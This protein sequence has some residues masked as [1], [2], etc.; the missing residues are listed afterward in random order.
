MSAKLAAAQEDGFLANLPLPQ[1][2]LAC[3]AITHGL[4]H[5]I[6]DDVD[7]LGALDADAA[8]K[9]AVEV[10][11]VLGYGLLPRAESPAAVL[12][13][14]PKAPKS[15]KPS[16]KKPRGAGA[17]VLAA[18]ALGGAH[19]D[20]KPAPKPIAGWADYNAD[21]N[22]V[23]AHELPADPPAGTYVLITAAG[24]IGV[25]AF[26]HTEPLQNAGGCPYEAELHLVD[27]PA[28]LP[29][30]VGGFAVVGP[31]DPGAAAAPKLLADDALGVPGPR[32]VS[33][34]RAIDL[35]GDGKA[36]L[37]FEETS[38]RGP[39]VNGVADVSAT[40]SVWARS[41]ARWSRT[42]HCAWHGHAEI[43]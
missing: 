19:A 24:S 29:A 38:K 17:L 14:A 9:L 7:G 16:K 4:A 10:T 25:L 8:A 39:F 1:I 32:G 37:V 5:M 23:L 42:S 33:P 22:Q 27:P 21:H 2:M 35:D 41:G 13:T 6:V 26:D 31:I 28:S 40:A 36:D 18:V 15:A 20:A 30:T 11:G 12:P 3:G 43:D 34:R